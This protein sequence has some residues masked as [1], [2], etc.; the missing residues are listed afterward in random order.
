MRVIINPATNFNCVFGAHSFIKNFPRIEID[1]IEIKYQCGRYYV[2]IDG[3]R[4]HDT[5]FFTPDEMKYL[6][7]LED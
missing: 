4:A 5:A 2:M 1:G 6:I 7:I 3:E